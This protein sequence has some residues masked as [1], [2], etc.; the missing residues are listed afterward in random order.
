M[1]EDKDSFNAWKGATE[2]LQIALNSVLG[3]TL[4][5]IMKNCISTVAEG[6]LSFLC[7]M[8]LLEARGAT[9]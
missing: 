6:N 4:A 7:L 2:K 8:L 5:K 3:R 1:G 9:E